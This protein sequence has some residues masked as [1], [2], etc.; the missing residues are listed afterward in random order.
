MALLLALAAAVV[1]GSSDFL[2]GLASRRSPV[3]A[4]V[5]VSQAVGLVALLPLLVVL[6]GRPALG[7]IGWG[8]ASGIAG[9]IGVALLYRG[10]SVGRMGVVAPTTAVGAAAVPVLFGLGVGERPGL[11][12]LVGIAV[13]L[14]AIVLVSATP[15]PGAPEGAGPGVGIA[16]PGSAAAPRV[17]VGPRRPDAD[18]GDP[19]AVAAPDAA[20][21]TGRLGAPTGRLP[22]GLLE[23]IGA[24]IAFGAFFILLAR[25]GTDSGL[26]PLVG[27]RAASIALV[28]AG[29]MLTGRSLRLVEGTGWQVAGSG[30]LDMV[31]NA[32]YLLATAT[33]LLSLVAV[34]TSLYPAST[35]VLARV[36]L[37]ERLAR[38]QVAGL[39][40]A[41]AGVV[42]ISLG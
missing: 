3:L 8:A 39:A 23:A 41:A 4:V 28:V 16:A 1:Y 42:L 38:V 6:P 13:A 35:V 30:V 15:S 17:R 20:G 36:V 21:V 29:A 33:G 32:L 34:V 2:G 27:A 10:L 25:A 40:C 31:A 12:A 19:P 7:A 5:A 14:V 26:W 11:A 9:G 18:V 24:G 37:H 22:A